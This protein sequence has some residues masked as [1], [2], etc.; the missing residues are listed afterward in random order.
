MGRRCWDP[1]GKELLRL[2]NAKQK[3]KRKISQGLTVFALL[4]FEYEPV[5]LK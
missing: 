1:I 4:F 5:E 3:A 2:T